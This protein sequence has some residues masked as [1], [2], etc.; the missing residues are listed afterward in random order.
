MEVILSNFG[1][2]ILKDNSTAS[3]MV[4]ALNG[5]RTELSSDNDI[6]IEFEDSTKEAL[7]QIN[8]LLYSS[9]WLQSMA[10]KYQVVKVRDKSKSPGEKIKKS[11]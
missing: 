1:T 4:R 11:K 2:T 10:E 6:Q 8:S 7:E 9:V 5:I 3:I